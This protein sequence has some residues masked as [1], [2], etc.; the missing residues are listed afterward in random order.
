M[1]KLQDH[2]CR[3]PRR[4]A[5]VL[6]VMSTAIVGCGNATHRVAPHDSQNPTAISNIMTI[7][8]AV[9]QDPCSEERTP[10]GYSGCD[11]RYLTQVQLIARTAASLAD[12][13][14]DPARVTS[15]ANGLS[16]TTTVLQHLSCHG[17]GQHGCAAALRAVGNSLRGLSAVLTPADPTTGTSSS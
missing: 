3:I 7:I 16:S 6:M 1:I 8:D 2:S 15:A 17:T 10:I 12:A 5:V 14:A 11:G 13:S 9:E 4:L